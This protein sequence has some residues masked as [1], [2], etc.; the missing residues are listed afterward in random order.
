MWGF[1]HILDQQKGSVIYRRSLATI[2]TLRAAS[3][4][5]TL[6]NILAMWLVWVRELFAQAAGEHLNSSALFVACAD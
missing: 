2:R 4:G 1:L 5:V 3:A 6:D